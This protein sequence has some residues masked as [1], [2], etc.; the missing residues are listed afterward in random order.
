MSAAFCPRSTLPIGAKRL[1]TPSST[2]SASLSPQP[3]TNNDLLKVHPGHL[4]MS[5]CIFFEVKTLLDNP[6]IHSPLIYVFSDSD[7]SVLCGLILAWNHKHR[8]NLCS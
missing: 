7:R 3:I 1:A 5:G 6:E 2:I 8:A 4:Y